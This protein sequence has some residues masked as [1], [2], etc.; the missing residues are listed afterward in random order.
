MILTAHQPSYLPWL[1]YFHKIALSDLFCVFDV[2]QYQTNDFNNRNRIKTNTGPM[3]LSVPVLSKNHFHLRLADAEVINRGWNRKHW[4]SILLAYQWAPYFADYAPELEEIILHRTF[5]RLTDLNTEML[6]M[7]LRWLDINVP[8]VFATDYDLQGKKSDLVLDMC[9]K[10]KASTY[11][12]GA[13]GRDYAD[14]AAFRA[15]G[16]E[17]Y[18]QDYKHP[19]YRQLNGPF[20]PYMSII[21]LVFNE[22]PRSKDIIMSGNITK[23]ELPRGV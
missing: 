22:G 8:I 21:D 13:L 20:V 18:F 1:G 11:I 23:S 6:R 14:V 9:L 4:R 17:P 15:A 12:F 2:A 10:L 16:V 3:W 19:E 7:F 5:T